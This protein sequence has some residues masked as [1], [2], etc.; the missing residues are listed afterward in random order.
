[1]AIYANCYA[2]LDENR[3]EILSDD[4]LLPS[5][6]VYV[7]QISQPGHLCHFRPTH[8]DVQFYLL[9][10]NN[11]GLWIEVFTR[12]KFLLKSKIDR[13]HDWRTDLF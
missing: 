13:L 7:L 2:L 4:L 5:L 11:K 12:L 3:E 1:M 10:K 6:D 9:R 8:P